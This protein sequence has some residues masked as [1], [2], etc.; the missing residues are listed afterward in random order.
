MGRS[1]SGKTG[2]LAMLANA[3]YRIMLHDFDQNSRVITNYLKPDHAKIYRQIYGVA[4]LTNNGMLDTGKAVQKQAVAELNRFV[5]QL[6]HWQTETEDLGTWDTWTAHDIVV[7]DSSTFM[8][9]MLQLAAYEHPKANADERAIYKYAGEFQ[10]K[11]LNDLCSDANNASVILTAHL[12]QVGEKDSQGNII[13][14]L[15]NIPTGVGVAAAKTIPSFFTDIWEIQV[16]AGGKRVIQ[17]A[18]TNKTPLRASSAVIKPIENYE[19][20]AS[21]FNRLLGA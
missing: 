12:Q 20:F 7:V 8:A 1:A 2:A 21:M 4:R 16:N 19:D 10:T 18:A 13:S 9:R 5:A 11:I 14:N 3:G 17:T 15:E 6:K